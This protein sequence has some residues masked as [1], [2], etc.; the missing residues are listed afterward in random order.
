MSRVVEILIPALAAVFLLVSLLLGL[1][2]KSYLKK[3]HL[4]KY[5]VKG[6]PIGPSLWLEIELL[7]HEN[8][9]PA[10]F[11]MAFPSFLSIAACP[12]LL[13]FHE[14]LVEAF[15]PNNTTPSIQDLDTALS[16]Y[17]IPASLVY[18][19][20]FSI[21]FQLA[22]TRFSG[23][24][25]IIFRETHLLYEMT[26][27]ATELKGIEVN[28][29]CCQDVLL[30]LVQQQAL[31]IAL[32]RCGCDSLRKCNC[33][34]N[35][36]NQKL[37]IK[38]VDLERHLHG[39]RRVSTKPENV[40]LRQMTK[41]LR[42]V[43]RGGEKFSHK[44]CGS[45]PYK[46]DEGSDYSMDDKIIER[47]LDCIFKLHECSAKRQ[48]LF[49]DTTSVF[50]WVIL[51]GVGLVVFFLILLTITGSDA[52]NTVMYIVTVLTVTALVYGIA[53][54]SQAFHGFFTVPMSR[55][56]SLLED[57]SIALE[58]LEAQEQEHPLTGTSFDHVLKCQ[59]DGHD[60]DHD[61][62]LHH[63]HQDCDEGV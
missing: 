5:V 49:S 30:I 37:P 13:A 17:L 39:P 8:E 50:E 27:L 48:A 45:V 41:A 29:A 55:L 10:L 35:Y 14:D 46:M 51:I 34:T 61:H 28:G 2:I 36:T 59:A 12:I 16:T 33:T 7:K 58:S 21:A 62:D 3:R 25:E 22:Y 56:V 15:Y 19:L 40:P 26:L 4:E 60:H 23:V 38:A 18:A 9:L 11:K 20:W 54:L 53:D 57:C 44:N 32:K 42:L 43:C 1:R 52:L 31:D 63:N 6:V 24:R 47:A